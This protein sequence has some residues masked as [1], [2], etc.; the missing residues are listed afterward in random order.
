MSQPRAS[1]WTLVLEGDLSVRAWLEAGLRGRGH[2]VL[3]C[4]RTEEAWEGFLHRQPQLLVLDWSDMG[5]PELCRRIRA[6]ANGE[7]CVVLAAGLNDRPQ[8]LESALEAGADDVLP[9]L[10]DAGVLVARLAVAERR[11]RRAEA[12]ARA[13]QHLGCLRKAVDIVPFGI[14]VTDLEGVIL[15]V[16]PAEADM[17]G[18]RVEELL[19]RNVRLLGCEAPGAQED[20]AEGAAAA[21]RA[22][23]VQWERERVQLRK[24]G[25]QV[26]VRLLSDVA[27][28]IQGEPLGFVTLCRELASGAPARESTRSVQ[29][30]WSASLLLAEEMRRP[31]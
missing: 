16:N 31:E 12:Q 7:R 8:A 19:G 1:V 9:K 17:H 25:S 10:A 28:G 14:T 20:P 24:D 22:S 27:C 21:S 13:E 4:A 18:Y 11:V 26:V 2:E 23:G 30:A 3:C 15:H 29:P 6:T 5:V